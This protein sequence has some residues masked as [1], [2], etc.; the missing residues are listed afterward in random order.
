[1]SKNMKFLIKTLFLL[2]FCFNLSAK[3]TDWQEIINNID[4]GQVRVLQSF[5]GE[6]N[7]VALQF[8]LK[9][10]WKIYGKDSGSVGLPPS[11]DFLG[12]KNIASYEV[13]WPEAINQEEVIGD[14]KISYSVYKDEVILPIQI[15]L[16]DAKKPAF[17][18]LSVNYGVCKNICVP[19]HSKFSFEALVM[20][21]SEVLKLIDGE[22]DFEN[23]VMTPLLYAILISFIGGLILNIMPC[24]LPVLGI[25]LVSIIGNRKAP[26]SRIKAAFFATFLG[27]LAC[28]FLFFLMAMFLAEVG[29]VFNW[30][31]QF[32]NPYFLIFLLLVLTFFTANMLGFFEVQ[33]SQITTNLIN[34]KISESEK[35]KNIFM[36]NFLSGILAVLL[37]TPC[38]APF[39]GSAISFSITQTP[40]IIFVIFLSM[41]IGF[42]FPY[43]LLMLRPS[44][45]YLM[46]KSG[47]WLLKVKKVMSGL[48]IATIIWLIYVL[49]HNLSFVSAMIMTFIILVIF[50][51]FKVKFAFLK[52]LLLTSLILSAFCLPNKMDEVKY[53]QKTAEDMVWVNFDENLIPYY[54]A[55]KKVVVVDVTADW[56]LTCKFNKYRILRDKKVVARLKKGDIVAM[57]A[58]I[59][60]PNKEVMMYINAKNRFAIPFNAVYGPNAKD[61][62]LASE[63]LTKKEL[64]GLIEKASSND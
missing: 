61:G 14:S 20:Q 46:P 45:V 51:A 22:K 19:A 7:V 1:M 28:F 21:D 43:L 59:T 48:L 44:L 53:T 41:A 58:D 30:G 60:R 40:I 16:E 3:T 39:L 38:S 47:S 37:A 34:K 6:N 18:E 2:F 64:L 32:Q 17:V 9:N 35:K 8:K 31:I 5:D 29:Q 15:K 49:S 62:L 42:A 55:K 4:T 12:S 25:K 54:I 27:I 36:P 24:V 57:R 10:G 11:F 52:Y 50:Y 33:F 26:T 13:L 23:Q 63:L 56:C